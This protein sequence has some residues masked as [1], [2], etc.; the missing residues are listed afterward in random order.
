[1]SYSAVSN[2]YDRL[3]RRKGRYPWG[4][5]LASAPVNEC[6]LYP[7]KRTLID[8]AAAATYGT[9]LQFAGG[10]NNVEFVPRYPI[11]AKQLRPDF[12]FPQYLVKR[13]QRNIAKLPELLSRR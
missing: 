9:L 11:F 8:G 10:S 6:P 3:W 5:G 13:N 2:F 12:S 1:L 7:Q 4:L